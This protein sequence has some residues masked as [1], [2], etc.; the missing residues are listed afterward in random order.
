MSLYSEVIAYGNANNGEYPKQIK[1]NKDAKS[2]AK[3]FQNLAKTKRNQVDNHDFDKSLPTLSKEKDEEMTKV[4]GVD[5]YKLK[6][7]SWKKEDD[8]LQWLKEFIKKRNLSAEDW[9]KITV[10]DFKNGGLGLI[11]KYNNS[12]KYNKCRKST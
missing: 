12:V 3:A 10:D 9:Y 6:K 4:F 5:W 11:D 1:N 7:Q 8:Q 2:I